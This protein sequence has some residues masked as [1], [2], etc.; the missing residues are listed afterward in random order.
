MAF[1]D[2]ASNTESKPQRLSDES[3]KNALRNKTSNLTKNNMYLQE[4]FSLLPFQVHFFQEK[5]IKI[6]INEL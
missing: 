1:L 4:N 3:C 5:R 6:R 2:P